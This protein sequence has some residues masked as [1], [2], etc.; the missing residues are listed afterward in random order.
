MTIL[1]RYSILFYSL[2][3]NS[4]AINQSFTLL[5]CFSLDFYP[6]PKDLCDAIRILEN[7]T[8]FKTDSNRIFYKK[9]NSSFK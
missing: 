8:V 4:N 7:V 6:Y 2:K 9:N 5:F 1:V 3:L